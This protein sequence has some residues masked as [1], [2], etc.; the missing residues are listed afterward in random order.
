MMLL[1]KVRTPLEGVCRGS[2]ILS[3]Y[4]VMFL[5][6]KDIVVVSSIDLTNDTTFL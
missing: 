4:V 1:S 6:A 5:T 3:T 2:T